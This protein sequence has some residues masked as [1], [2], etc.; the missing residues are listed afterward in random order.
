M[1]KGQRHVA[2]VQLVAQMQAGHSWQTAAAKARLQ[3]SQSNAY[4]LWGA[5][6]QHGETALSDGRH[7]HPSKLRGAV[8]AFLEE[9]CQQAPHTPSSTIQVELRERFDL[10]V[11]ISQINRVRRQLG[12]SN[13]SKNGEP[14]KKRRKRQGLPFKKSGRKAQGACCYWQLLT[15]RNC[16]PISS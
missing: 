2:K 1:D 15:K 14:G 4:R 12:V 7:G 6:R 10:Q 11:S 16:C 5:F 13:H 3:I 8:R 9:Q